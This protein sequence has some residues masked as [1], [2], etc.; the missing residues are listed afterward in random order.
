[1]PPRS[2]KMKRFIFGFQRRV[3]CPKWTPAS[4]S[5]FMVTTATMGSLPVVRCASRCAGAGPGAPKGDRGMA[6]VQGVV[7][8]PDRRSPGRGSMLAAVLSATR[9]SASR[10]RQEARAAPARSSARLIP[11]P[12]AWSVQGVAEG[13]AA[14]REPGQGQAERAG[15]LGAPRQV[16]VGGA[17]DQGHHHLVH[18]RRPRCGARAR[19]GRPGRRSTR[20][21]PPRAP[22]G[23]ASSAT[24]SE[25][26]LSWATER[27]SSSSSW[28]VAAREASS[29]VDAA[30]GCSTGRGPR[31]RGRRRRGASRGWRPV[32][33]G[34]A[35]R[36]RGGARAR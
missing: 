25:V 19:S 4:S 29:A 6:R 7:W 22:G 1:M 31:W 10:S 20:R 32:P 34:R 8:D 16:A 24:T 23:A 26:S 9:T 30:T 5:C 35:T 2:P 17:P 28:S 15:G 18:P 36:R 14:R 11:S 33:A 27:P 12:T 13:L 3:W 21:P